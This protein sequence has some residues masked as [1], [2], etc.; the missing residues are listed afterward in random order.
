MF[1]SGRMH[2]ISKNSKVDFTVID[3]LFHTGSQAI[4]DLQQ[5]TNSHREEAHLLGQS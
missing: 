4:G 5:S 1:H 2:D 3:K